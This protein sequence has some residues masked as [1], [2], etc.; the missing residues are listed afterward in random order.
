[1]KSLF[2]VGDKVICIKEAI[3]LS[4]IVC[5]KYGEIYKIYEIYNNRNF[6]NIESIDICIN[7]DI[8]RCYAER[9]IK[10]LDRNKPENKKI[11]LELI[12]KRLLGK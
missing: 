4:S 10:Y 2:K 6:H 8:K 7:G 1:M 11:M 3:N 9:F 5:K 12:E